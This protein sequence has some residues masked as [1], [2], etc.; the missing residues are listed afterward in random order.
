MSYLLEFDSHHVTLTRRQYHGLTRGFIIQELFRRVEPG[1]RSIG[2]FLKAEV[3]D[4]LALNISIGLSEEEQKKRKL[5][6]N[7]LLNPQEVRNIASNGHCLFSLACLDPDRIL[8]CYSSLVLR[9]Y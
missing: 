1:H 4:P 8:N 9:F 6:D 3:F 2:T 7:V 5:A